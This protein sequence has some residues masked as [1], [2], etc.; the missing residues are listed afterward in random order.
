MTPLWIAK[1]ACRETLFYSYNKKGENP[2]QAAKDICEVYGP[3]AVSEQ[4]S[5]QGSAR[6]KRLGSATKNDV[7]FT[8]VQSETSH[9]LPEH[10]PISKKSV[11]KLDRLAW[12]GRSIQTYIRHSTSLSVSIP[13]HKSPA[14]RTKS[15]SGAGHCSRPRLS[16][17]IALD[18]IYVRA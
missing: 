4:S 12:S 6:P 15:A 9:V 18:L 3:N 8:W 7:V 14:G 5:P 1:R 17:I 2:T 10:F 13:P 11:S 16:L